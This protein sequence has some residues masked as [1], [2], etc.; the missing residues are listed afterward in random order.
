MQLGLL[1]AMHNFSVRHRSQYHPPVLY[2]VGWTILC[3][4][5][6]RVHVP[7]MCLESIVACFFL[8]SLNDALWFA[9]PPLKFWV[10]PMYIK[11]FFL[12]C[13]WKWPCRLDK[14]CVAFII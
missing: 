3:L 7:I 6:A 5:L 12:P 10:D 11:C 9:C 8:S 2:Y 1:R 14:S 4:G 13:H